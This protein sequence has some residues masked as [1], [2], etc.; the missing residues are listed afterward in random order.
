MKRLFA[1]T[2]V[3]DNNAK[4]DIYKKA[5]D[6]FDSDRAKYNAACVYLDLM[7]NSEAKALLEKINDKKCYYKNAM[8]V[9]AMREGKNAEAMKWFNDCHRP[10]AK[11]N[12]AVID[13]L[14]GRYKEA[15]T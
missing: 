6:K 10:E 12:A 13:I 1:A 4:L 3:K 2:L 5:I 9:I 8:G 11:I 7:K 15:L 14:E